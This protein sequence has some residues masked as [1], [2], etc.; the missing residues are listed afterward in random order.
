M[1]R[2][3]LGGALVVS[4]ALVAPFGVAVAGAGATPPAGTAGSSCQASGQKAQLAASAAAAAGFPAEQL[5]TAVAIAG[6]ESGYDPTATHLNADGS[7][8]YG[9][10]QINGVHADLLTQGDWRDPAANARMAFAVWSAAGRSWTPWST[11]NSGAYV[12][13]LAEA[14]AAI[15]G[16]PAPVCS[17]PGGSVPADQAHAA[18]LALSRTFLGLPYLWGGST[19]AGFD[20]SGLVMYVYA[21]AAGVT[22][23]RTAA[24]QQ[25]A[26]TP[27]TT[28]QPGDLVFFGRPAS[29]V[30]IVLDP[31]LGTMLDA[32]HTGAVIREE[33][34]TTWSDL[35]GFGTFLP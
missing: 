17:A 1:K 4:L 31:T 21:N 15:E 13:H 35:D 26:A 33:Q 23:P 24:A 5:P 7:T 2:A 14:T 27:T 18:I 9:L 8:D 34:Y 6:A 28:P 30:G 32:P 3:L 22:V 20:C 16:A 11:Y 12:A 29:H 19:P 25:A 10:W